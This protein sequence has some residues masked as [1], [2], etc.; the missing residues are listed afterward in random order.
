MSDRAEE[1][2]VPSGGSSKLV[3]RSFTSPPLPVSLQSSFLLSILKHLRLVSRNLL[4][5]AWISLRLL[6]EDAV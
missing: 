3:I 4:F 5:P 1:K 6:A 2:L